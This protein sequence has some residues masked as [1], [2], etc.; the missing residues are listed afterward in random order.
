LI[1]T[2]RAIDQ[3]DIVAAPLG[4]WG[5]IIDAMKQTIERRQQLASQNFQA[6]INLARSAPSKKEVVSKIA[7]LCNSGHIDY[8]FR[9]ILDV[10]TSACREQGK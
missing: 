5:A 7:S 10:T 4:C 2:A 9:G 6:L 3:S 8:L 1:S